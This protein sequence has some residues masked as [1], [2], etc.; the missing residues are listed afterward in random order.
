MI[1]TLQRAQLNLH[2]ISKPSIADYLNEKPLRQHFFMKPKTE[3]LIWVLP[4]KL[5]KFHNTGA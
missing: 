3:D 1:C 2:R 5:N 4:T